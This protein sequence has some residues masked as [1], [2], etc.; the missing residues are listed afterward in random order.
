MTFL[1]ISELVNLP[2]TDNAVAR[3]A[4]ANSWIADQQKEI[5]DSSTPS[6]A[7]SATTK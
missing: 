7:L 4:D 3:V 2:L 6:A 1:Y 5:G